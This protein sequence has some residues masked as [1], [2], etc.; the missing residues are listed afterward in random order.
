MVAHRPLELEWTL[1]N[2]SL[3]VQL[4]KVRLAEAFIY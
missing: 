3:V 2:P 1:Q 4:R